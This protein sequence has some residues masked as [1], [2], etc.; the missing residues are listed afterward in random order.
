MKK[1]AIAKRYAKALLEIGVEE[2]RYKEIGNELR[3]ISSVF[4]ANPELN[5][6]L[7]NPMYKLEDRHGLV[8]KV[9]GAVEVSQVVKKFL[10][11]LVA[12]R[13]I[14]LIEGISGAYTRMEDDL[15]GRIK[16]NVE[17][18]VELNESRIAEIR[19]RL[20]E[21]TKEEV[22]LSV[23]KNTALIG[24]LVFRIG[25]TILDGSIKK[26]LERVREGITQL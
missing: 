24:G 26:Q 9:A 17:A 4:A 11:L 8:E 25:N 21:I 14:A 20:Q 15:S 22:I 16:V 12:T 3:D 19:K 6:F 18:A 13:A 23:E 5:K 1:T 7:L 10:V 2:K